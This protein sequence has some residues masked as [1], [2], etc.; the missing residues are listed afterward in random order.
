MMKNESVAARVHPIESLITFANMRL[1]PDMVDAINLILLV[2]P[3][4]SNRSIAGTD[5]N[6]DGFLV[7][8]VHDCSPF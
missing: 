3:S 7:I 8:Q 4:K 5:A 1:T 6:C 2:S